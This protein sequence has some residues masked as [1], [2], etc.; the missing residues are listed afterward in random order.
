MGKC[1]FIPVGGKTPHYMCTNDTLVGSTCF[2]TCLPTQVMQGQSE[3][4]CWENNSGEV[5][6]TLD[7]PTCVDVCEETIISEN[8]KM[9]CS[10][11]NRVGSTC[12]FKCV[13]GHKLVGAQ[14]VTCRL[15]PSTGTNEWSEAHPVCLPKCGPIRR[16]PFGSVACTAPTSSAPSASSSARGSTN[17]SVPPSSSA[18]PKTV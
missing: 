17:S 2:F 12:S 3:T 13:A 11:R 1:A 18:A 6:W 8:T 7:T 14:Q 10:D 16:I 15:A 5:A 9:E 4:T